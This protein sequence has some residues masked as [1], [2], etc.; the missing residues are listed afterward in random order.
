MTAPLAGQ[1]AINWG[2]DSGMGTWILCRGGCSGSG[3]QWI[4]VVLYSKIVHYI[5]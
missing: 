1:P 2:V 4:G 3:V 5:I